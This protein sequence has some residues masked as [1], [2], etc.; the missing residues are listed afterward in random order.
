MLEWNNKR[1]TLEDAY[2]HLIKCEKLF[3]SLNKELVLTR[4]IFEQLQNND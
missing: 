2:K 1:A 4:K 3:N